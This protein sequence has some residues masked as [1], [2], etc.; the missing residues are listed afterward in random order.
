[1]HVGLLDGGISVDAPEVS[2]SSESLKASQS[3]NLGPNLANYGS[4]ENGNEYW[5][6]W[7]SEFEKKSNQARL[8]LTRRLSFSHA[9]GLGAADLS[10]MNLNGH[11]I[12]DFN[13]SL[14]D[15]TETA[16]TSTDLPASINLADFGLK[17][18][19]S[20]FGTDGWDVT[21][22]L[23]DFSVI[24]E[25][26]YTILSVFIGLGAVALRRRV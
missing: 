12:V 14:S 10:P 8:A 18:G 20:Q 7:H 6:L 19:V 4:F 26:N 21:Y 5:Y 2:T 13:L 1:M 15:F 22:N 23:T 3:S 25:P 16:F 11:D 9:G 24:P 17:Q